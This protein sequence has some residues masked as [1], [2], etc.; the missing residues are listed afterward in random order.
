MRRPALAPALVP[1]LVLLAALAS[2]TPARAQSNEAAAEALFNEGTALVE[3]GHV[4]AGCKKLEA[5]EALD[6]AT[7]TLIHLGDCYEKL[8][9]T[10]SA[11]AR[12]REAA[13][14]ASKDGRTDW[15]TVAKARAGELEP[16]L[17]RL[18]VD[19]PA[20]VAVRRDGQDVP[21]AAYGSALPVDPGDYTLTASAPRKKT[22]TGKVHVD[23][24]ALAAVRVP[25][26]EDDASAATGDGRDAHA[27]AQTDEGSGSTLRTIGWA[28]G[29]VGIVGVAVGGVSGL[30]AI[31]Q[32]DKSKRV[33]PNDGLCADDTARS[34]NAS[35]R[36]AATISTIGFIA[37]G[38]LLAGGVALV[39]AAPAASS[40]SAASASSSSSS[41]RLRA[42]P[43]A[44]FLEGTF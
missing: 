18:K 30:I 7:G 21:P 32:N 36:T 28:A 37:G 16:K 20:G 27:G 17:A 22:W 35:A 15:E 2:A 10:A 9:R 39:L 29:A 25:A 12:F 40:A 11:W 1:A 41:A 13:S 42:A 23:A 31:G 19:A 3:A 33:C 8:G 44:L 4:E 26:L 24:A 34:E 6:P 5:S 38:A 14:R 43:G